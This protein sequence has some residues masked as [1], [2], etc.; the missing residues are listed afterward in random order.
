MKKKAYAIYTPLFSETEAENNLA[1]TPTRE[2]NDSPAGF[3]MYS[4]YTH[5]A[6]LGWNTKQVH[7]LLLCPHKQED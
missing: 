3:W 5:L 6:T 1:F 2:G 7:P 4:Q